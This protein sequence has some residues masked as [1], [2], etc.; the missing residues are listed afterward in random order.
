MFHSDSTLSS[1]VQS[2]SC[3]DRQINQ[4][5]ESRAVKI[6]RKKLDNGE[7]IVN[8]MSSDISYLV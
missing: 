1:H 4:T 6:L 5:V 8:Q 7:I 2:K 3:V